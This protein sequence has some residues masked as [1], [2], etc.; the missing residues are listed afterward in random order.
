MKQSKLLKKSLAALLAILMVAAMIP[1]SAFAADGDAIYVDGIQAV[2][3]DGSYSVTLQYDQEN[4]AAKVGAVEFKLSSLKGTTVTLLDKDGKNQ[5]TASLS[6]VPGTDSAK[7]TISLKTTGIDAPATGNYGEYKM[8]VRIQDAGAEAAQDYPLTIK[9]EER[10]KR[11]NVAIAE[12]DGITGPDVIDYKVEGNVIT[13][14]KAIGKAKK[15]MDL[16]ITADDTASTVSVPASKTTTIDKNPTVD[17][18]PY[19]R[20]LSGH[21]ASDVVDGVRIIAEDGSYQDYTINYVTET[22]FESISVPGQIGNPTVTEDA[23]GV[24]YMTFTVPYGKGDAGHELVPTFTVSKDVDGIVTGSDNGRNEA[25]T[26]NHGSY[27]YLDSETYG[28]RNVSGKVGLELDDTTNGKSGTDGVKL[29]A[30]TVNQSSHVDP[31]VDEDKGV[32]HA[33][34]LVLRSVMNRNTEAAITDVAVENV[35]SHNYEQD[36]VSLTNTTA[37]QNIVIGDIT[38]NI[39]NQNRNLKFK[40]P[41]GAVV[42]ISNWDTSEHV[43]AETSN[44]DPNYASKKNGTAA[45]KAS[46]SFDFAGIT[47]GVEAEKSYTITYDGET[48]TV[49]TASG[50]TDAAAIATA[51]KNAGLTSWNVTVTNNTVVKLEQKTASTKATATT[52]AVAGTSG[53]AADPSG[54]LTGAPTLVAGSA[55][56]G[57]SGTPAEANYVEFA[58]VPVYKFTR[59]PMRVT[60]TS[61]DRSKV[62]S[63]NLTFSGAPASTPAT[64]NGIK[65]Y[66]SADDYTGVS[67]R[68]ID[69]DDVV[70]LTSGQTPYAIDVSVSNGATAE[71]VWQELSGTS[72]VD[73]SSNS[74]AIVGDRVQIYPC[75]VTNPAAPAHGSNTVEYV[76]LTG[77]AKGYSAKIIVHAFYGN[78][79]TSNAPTSGNCDPK[80]EK[81][82]Y[83]KNAD[84]RTEE[85]LTYAHVTYSKDIS[86]LDMNETN[87]FDVRNIDHDNKFIQIDVPYT[88]NLDDDGKTQTTNLYLYKSSDL[89]KSAGSSVVNNGAAAIAGLSFTKLGVQDLDGK[90]ATPDGN[91]DG[92]TVFATLTTP[93]ITTQAE[94]NAG[95]FDRTNTSNTTSV[96]VT[97]ENGRVRKYEAYAVRQAAS[98]ACDLNSISS[99]DEKVTIALDD[100]PGTNRYIITVPHSYNTETYDRKKT[101]SFD[102]TFD[103]SKNATV[104]DGSTTDPMKFF[105]PNVTSRSFAVSGGRLYYNGKLVSGD[106]FV[107]K[108]EDGTATK[109]Y[110]FTVK[111]LPANT[112]STIT[113]ITVGDREA[114]AGE[115][116]TFTATVPYGKLRQKLA[117]VLGSELS[118][119]TINERD[120]EPDREYDLTNELP[121]TVTAEDGS[122]SVY[123]LTVTEAEPS[124][125]AELVSLK[126]GDKNARIDGTDVTAKIGEDADLT[127]QVLTIEVSEAASYTVAGRVYDNTAIAV[128]EPVEI[129]VTAEDGK[130]TKTYTLTVLAEDVKTENTITGASVDGVDATIADTAI[131]AEAENPASVMLALTLP[132]GAT[133]KVGETEYTAGM[134][135]DASSPVTIVVTAEDGTEKTYT[136]TVTKK[137]GATLDGVVDVPATHWAA[138]AIADILDRGIMTTNSKDQ[139]LPNDTVSRGMFAVMMCQLYGVDPADYA[140]AQNPFTDIK[141]GDWFYNAALAAVDHD[142]MAGTSKTTFSPKDPVT[143]EQT[144]LIIAKAQGLSKVEAPAEAYSDDAR[145]ASWAKGWVYA[146]KDAGLMGYMSTS[147]KTFNPKG[148][149]TRAQMAMILTHINPE[150][151][152]PETPDE[153]DTPETPDEGDTPETP[154]EGDT[155]ET[156]DEGDTPETPD[157]GDTPETPDEGDT[158]ETPAE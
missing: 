128:N 147:Q 7:R 87:V 131:T 138:Q 102:I 93:K 18:V 79:G 137:G 37:T 22:I 25:V 82:F 50:G 126:V 115:N 150:T 8:V 116:K 67:A 100:I 24:V 125:E 94:M 109:Q 123:K 97:A 10:A 14:T 6:G 114:V 119:V 139:F 1:M 121:I 120:Y 85:L 5:L 3:E 21:G 42:A 74:T 103:V 110:L 54:T 132:E 77:H 95:T 23:N 83:V 58:N 61:E 76:P 88:F 2:L 13:V 75:N 141:K 90:P 127:K 59:T 19:I 29:Y 142:W 32:S 68:T 105:G 57:V 107:V 145:I 153:G 34:N 98:S 36:L 4:V 28:R 46:V 106:S 78:D 101:P 112:D 117:I 20:I 15:D 38:G 140:D 134:T 48:A 157:E 70:S 91:D 17:N 96:T 133:A 111:T 49:T 33:A 72:D 151:D 144:A 9:V 89:T 45:V 104:Q 30:S 99:P 155:P 122:I 53:G 80:S 55:V 136:L 124:T 84:A 31:A 65:V 12:D 62:V 27:F 143:R 60:V 11:R 73:H 66:T 135:V 41:N 149:L 44:S 118:K 86:N 69:G 158:P 35:T 156:P 16:T 64:V 52:I 71:T 130:T 154:D 39:T 129:V 43:V 108:A 40:V 148:E 146:C 26:A 56:N 92:S 113:S 51:F 152:E 47:A 63:Y 81:I